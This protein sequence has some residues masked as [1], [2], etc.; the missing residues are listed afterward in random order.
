M[1]TI[2]G[3]K[4]EKP[5]DRAWWKSASVYQSRSLQVKSL[6]M[7]MSSLSRK[8]SLIAIASRETDP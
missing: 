6:H 7:L 4:V 2:I 5:S 3:P 8:S 1:S